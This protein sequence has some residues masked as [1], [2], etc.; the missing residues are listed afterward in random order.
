MS[1]RKVRGTGWAGLAK[2]RLT[3]N[4][5]QVNKRKLFMLKLAMLLKIQSK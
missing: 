5:R 1:T 3:S 4:T 2:G